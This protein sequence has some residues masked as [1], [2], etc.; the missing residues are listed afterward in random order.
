MDGRLLTFSKNWLHEVENIFAIWMLAMYLPLIMVSIISST[1]Q[2]SRY[3]Q[4]TKK[5]EYLQEQPKTYP[6]EKPEP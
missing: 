6:E 4:E 2:D 3:N 1:I 5:W